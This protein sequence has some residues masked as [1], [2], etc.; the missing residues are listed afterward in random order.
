[1]AVVKEDD[2]ACAY[3]CLC[4]PLKQTGPWKHLALSTP[5]QCM[6][7]GRCG[8]ENKPTLSRHICPIYRGRY[9]VKEP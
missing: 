7:G 8:G 4:V 2:V 9:E 6:V 3:V 5:T 1:M